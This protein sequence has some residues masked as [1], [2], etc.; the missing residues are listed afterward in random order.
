MIFTGDLN[1]DVLAFDAE[2]GNVLWR[3]AAG[4]AVGGGVITYQAGGHQRVAVA[5]GMSSQIWPV[6]PTTA[7]VIVYCLP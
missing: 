5:A 2:S 4:A 1:G 7:R 3:D 6:K